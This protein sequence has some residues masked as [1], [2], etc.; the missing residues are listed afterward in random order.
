MPPE[1]NQPK[2][3]QNFIPM[4]EKCFIWDLSRKIKP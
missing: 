2:K 3:E 1:G 4:M